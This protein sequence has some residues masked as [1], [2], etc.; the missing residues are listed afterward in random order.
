MPEQKQFYKNYDPSATDYIYGRVRDQIPGVGG[1]STVG[2]STT[3]TSATGYGFAGVKA[4]DH[5]VIFT[6]EATAV[7]RTVA[8]VTSP[9]VVVLTVAINLALSNLWYHEPFDVGAA[10]T[11]G[12]HRVAGYERKT[13][14]L[15][16]ETV[17][18]TGGLSVLIQGRGN[19]D[20]TYPVNIL[21]R[22]FAAA[23]QDNTVIPI[24]EDITDLRI[25][26]KF[27]TSDVAG[28]DFS[29]FVQGVRNSRG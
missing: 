7:V 5:L 14:H 25:G 29:A 22:V 12:W 17:N 24:G 20:D 6:A 28:D 9:A 10:V 11:D 4:G 2:S 3:L 16:L 13:V 19:R 21:E 15:A 1:I 23:T 18:S 27:V 8:S 26:V